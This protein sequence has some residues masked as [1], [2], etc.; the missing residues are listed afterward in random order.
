MEM[1]I[2]YLD[3]WLLKVENIV[4]NIIMQKE[5][6]SYRLCLAEKT[7]Y[8]NLEYNECFQIINIIVN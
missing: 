5:S 8:N 7:T 6:T 3:N 4:R 1:T 2:L